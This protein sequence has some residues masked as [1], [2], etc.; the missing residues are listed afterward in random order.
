MA[1]EEISLSLRI[2]EAQEYS[3]P[4]T[5]F[6][7]CTLYACIPLGFKTFVSIVSQWYL[8]RLSINDGATRS[9]TYGDVVMNKVIVK[10]YVWN[11]RFAVTVKLPLFGITKSRKKTRTWPNDQMCKWKQMGNQVRR[12]LKVNAIEY[13]L[14]SSYLQHV[15]DNSP[16]ELTAPAGS[17]W[18]LPTWGSNTLLLFLRK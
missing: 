1:N 15:S 6:L 8:H 13:C 11:V 9:W 16:I 10:K 3:N 2:T 7:D 17:L 5:S 4:A 14:V 18:Q 12:H